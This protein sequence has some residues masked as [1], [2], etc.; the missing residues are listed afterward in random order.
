MRRCC[1]TCIDWTPYC[2]PERPASS[3][4]PASSP[5]KSGLSS[6]QTTSTEYASLVSCFPSLHSSPIS[7]E[8]LPGPPPVSQ[9]RT[10]IGLEEVMPEGAV[11]PLH[12]H[13]SAHGVRKRKLSQHVSPMPSKRQCRPSSPTGRHCIMHPTPSFDR[14]PDLCPFPGGHTDPEVPQSTLQIPINSH[15]SVNF[16]VFDWNSIPDPLTETAPSLC[17]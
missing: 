12:A 11:S 8:S 10:G 1:R 4:S 9:K 2:E 7:P 16:G 17:M 5:L 6:E 13:I 15:A 3:S 14:C